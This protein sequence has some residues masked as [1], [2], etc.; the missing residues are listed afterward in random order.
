MI[1]MGRRMGS[2]MNIRKPA[3]LVADDDPAIVRSIER[4]LRDEGLDIRTAHDGQAALD[5]AARHRIDL[6]ILDVMMPGL[7]GFDVCARLRAAAAP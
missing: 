3:V 1:D 5:V 2:E 7:N 4:T 6:F